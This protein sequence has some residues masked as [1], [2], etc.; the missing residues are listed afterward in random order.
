MTLYLGT[1]NVPE[2][3]AANT[4]AVAR[5]L[6]HRGQRARRHDEAA[7]PGVGESHNRSLY[8][9]RVAHIDRAR[10][11]TEGRCGSLDH[12]ELAGPGADVGIA[13]YRCAFKVRRDLLEK[14]EP[15]ASFYCGLCAIQTPMLTPPSKD[16]Y[17]QL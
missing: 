10:F 16:G 2:N 1:N 11:Q 9:G 6:K 5:S 4:S 14:F 15:F 12:G 17:F 7:I 13:Y 3:C 8:C